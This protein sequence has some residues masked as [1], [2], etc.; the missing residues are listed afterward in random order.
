MNMNDPHERLR[1]HVTGAIERGEVKPIVELISMQGAFD[2]AALGVIK[3]GWPATN[4]LGT[5]AYYAK[6]PDTG[7]VRYCGIGHLLPDDETR[8]R[9]DNHVGALMDYSVSN[10]EL[11]KVG[12]GHLPLKFLHELQ[13][14]HDGAQEAGDDFLATFKAKMLA[15]AE[16]WD[17]DPSVVR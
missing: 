8:I 2:K 13:R 17:L 9:W 1:Y 16:R 3:Q 11:N 4:D 12:L 5:C 7:V 15:V 14:A 6:D 10:D